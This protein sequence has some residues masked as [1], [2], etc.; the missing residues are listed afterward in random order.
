M[1]THLTENSKSI[2][3]CC[4]SSCSNIPGN[5]RANFVAK[6]ALILPVAKMKIPP[7][8]HIHN[9]PQFCMKESQDIW[10]SCK[11]NKLHAM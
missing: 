8:E 3:M 2:V 4:I 1:T 5:D 7:N 6:S 10:N 11:G 9:V